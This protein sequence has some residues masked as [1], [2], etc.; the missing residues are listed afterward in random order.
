MK[1]TPLKIGSPTRPQNSRTN[2]HQ[3]SY[4]SSSGSGLAS[5]SLKSLHC[6]SASTRPGPGVCEIFWADFWWYKNSS[7]KMIFD[8]VHQNWNRKDTFVIGNTLPQLIQTSYLSGCDFN[9][10]EYQCSSLLLLWKC[11]GGNS[12][13]YRIVY[14]FQYNHTTFSQTSTSVIPTWPLQNFWGGLSHPRPA[15][16]NPSPAS[17]L[18]TYSI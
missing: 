8:G 14:L 5:A 16:Y 9:P 1:T 6:K 18:Q 15:A 12:F 10:W 11:V 13:N 17:L 2:K 7:S 4:E 3:L